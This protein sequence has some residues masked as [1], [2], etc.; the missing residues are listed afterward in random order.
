VC[1]Q[2][3]EK[4]IKWQ[5]T[6]E[7]NQEWKNTKRCFLSHLSHG[8]SA[9]EIVEE[10]MSVP[11]QEGMT[12]EIKN[13][14]TIMDEADYFGVRVS[15]DASLEG[16]RTPLKIDFSTGDIFYAFPPSL[17]QMVLR[18]IPSRLAAAE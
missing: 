8:D 9:R 13:I 1:T 7:R 11:I 5:K 14:T 15:L 6:H 10:I 18:L 12:F 16:M 17:R 2:A 4:M 3:G